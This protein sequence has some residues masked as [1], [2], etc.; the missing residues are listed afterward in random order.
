MVKK[1]IKVSDILGDSYYVYELTSSNYT[2]TLNDTIIILCIMRDIYGTAASGKSI[3]LYQ[4]GVNKG[5]QTTNSSGV[6]TWSIT[7]STAGL[8]K[9]NIKDT[10]IEVFVDNKADSTHI[11]TIDLNS[12]DFYNADNWRTLE[13]NAPT[14]TSNS[15]QAGAVSHNILNKE[16]LKSKYYTLTF[17]FNV[18]PF[19]VGLYLFG[20]ENCN[21]MFGV[22]TDIKKTFVEQYNDNGNTTKLYDGIKDHFTEGWHDIKIIRKGDIA[23]IY[24]DDELYYSFNNIGNC[25][26]I[27]GLFK[28]GNGSVIIQNVDVSLDVTELPIDEIYDA[29]PT[30]NILENQD[31]ILTTSFFQDLNTYITYLDENSTQN[32]GSSSVAY[33]DGELIF[34]SGTIYGVLNY[35]YD[36]IFSQTNYYT[37]SF[38]IK[39]PSGTY[40]GKDFHIAIGDEENAVSFMFGYYKIGCKMLNEDKAQSESGQIVNA[41]EYTD[42]SITRNG[43]MWTLDYNNGEYVGT[44]TSYDNAIVN[45]LIVRDMNWNGSG[46][47]YIKDVVIKPKKQCIADLI[48]PIGS[49]YMSVNNVSPQALF[50]GIWEQIKDTFLLSSGDTYTNGSTGGEATHTLT[51]N[52]MPS[53]THIQNS[54]NH[55]QNSHN[56]TQNAHN[57]ALTGSK[58]VGIQEGD[59]L[60]VGYGS[61]SGGKNTNNTTATNKATTATN[62]SATATNQ[63]TGGGQAHNNMPPYLT[64]YMWKRTA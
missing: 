50:G 45:K 64:V 13:G 22:V 33:D 23:I 19:R 62:K 14:I 43:N 49:I 20:D 9:F 18:T 40:I 35:D 55:T 47:I 36:H 4:N 48:Y 27:F 29:L 58:S 63:N 52:E 12:F 24:I 30:S 6:A 7:C 17:E 21:R 25:T 37:I 32:S 60:R 59:K 34:T 51:E 28:W 2:P 38:K 26:N 39:K 8:Q 46:T 53:H 42:V 3:T 61:K 56:H 16:F 1:K 15:I 10:N 31:T 54:H 11:H 44:V 57:H 5:S 41:S